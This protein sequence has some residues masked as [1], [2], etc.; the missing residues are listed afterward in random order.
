MRGS[1][2]IGKKLILSFMCVALI[3]LVLGIVAYYGAVKS[4]GSVEEIGNVRL[5]GVDS[6]LIIKAN[7]E[8]VRGT[9][10]T[11]AI[12]GLDDDVRQRQYNNLTAARESYE[13]AWKI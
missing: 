11:L 8:N 6:L 4:E 7:A 5:S 2:T 13:A 9:M 3:T 10:R 1:W 12:P